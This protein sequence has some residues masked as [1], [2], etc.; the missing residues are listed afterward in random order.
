VDDNAPGPGREVGAATVEEF[1]RLLKERER[2]GSS[3]GEPE[4]P[5]RRA[6]F[7]ARIGEA[8]SSRYGFP[9][10]IRYVLAAFACGWDVV[11][12]RQLTSTAVELPETASTLEER[13]RVSYEE[14]LAEVKR[15]LEEADLDVSLY[16]GSLRSFVEPSSD[17]REGR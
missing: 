7:V 17:E 5:L 4:A 13:Q 8:R 16:E 9:K 6:V 14:L 10:V 12:H 2:G 1:L 15:G 3:V 11:C